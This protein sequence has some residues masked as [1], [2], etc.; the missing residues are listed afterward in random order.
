MWKWVGHSPIHMLNSVNTELYAILRNEIEIC[1]RIAFMHSIIRSSWTVPVTGSVNI[2][3]ETHSRDEIVES[4]PRSLLELLFWWWHTVAVMNYDIFVDS[5]W[6][7]VRSR[8]TRSEFKNQGPPP[9][10]HVLSFSKKVYIGCLD[11]RKTMMLLQKMTR[12]F[13]PT[14]D[15]TGHSCI[16]AFSDAC[17][18]H[19]LPRFR[20]L[21]C[22]RHMSL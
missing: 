15:V 3:Q 17:S 10:E 13:T 11:Q 2:G 21:P 18:L 16:K 7:E 14:R 6:C 5:G 9:K 20:L 22:P 4:A 19:P 12:M 1:A 8:F